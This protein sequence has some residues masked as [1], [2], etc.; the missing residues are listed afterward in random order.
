MTFEDLL[1]TYGP[2]GCW[3]AW[4]LFEKSKMLLKFSQMLDKNTE[5]LKEIKLE[6]SRRRK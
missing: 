2:L 3:T 4:L 5:M 1:V 6:I